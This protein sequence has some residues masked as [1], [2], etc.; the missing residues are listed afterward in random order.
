MTVTSPYT[1]PQPD[2]V[3]VLK[4]PGGLRNSCARWVHLINGAPTMPDDELAFA[5]IAYQSQLLRRGDLSPVE[6]TQLYLDRIDAYDEHLNAYLTVT[7]E[8]AIASAR[9]AEAAIQGGDW[10]GPLHGIP[11]ALKDLFDVVGLPTT[12]GS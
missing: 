12:A 11:V 1:R 8:R 5:T 7:A 2:W 10:R 4:Q 9:A 6:L 3:A